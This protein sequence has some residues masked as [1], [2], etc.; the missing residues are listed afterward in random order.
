MIYISSS[1]VKTNFI[2][3]A[4]IKLY[5][6]GF[7]HIELSGG[8][9]YY[10]EIEI[11]IIE[12]KEQ[13]NLNLLCHNYFPPPK[14][15]FVLNLA[16]L[17]NEIN[18]TTIKH[19]LTAIE[20]SKKIQ[21]DCFGFHAGFL[22]DFHTDEIGKRISY[23]KLYDREKALEKFFNGYKILEQNAGNIKLY[24]ENNV[25]SQSNRK[26]FKNNNPFLLTNSEDYFEFQKEINFN[27][28][29]DIAH[30]KVSSQTLG[31]DYESELNKLIVYSDYWHLSDNDGRHDTNCPFD[32]K[33]NIFKYINRSSQRILTLE[34][35][36]DIKKI[37][38]IYRL[39]KTKLDK[40]TL[41]LF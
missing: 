1:C 8:T 39:L 18:D 29:L 25:F 27:L 5:N 24:I 37:Q 28:L 22:I 3:E 20:L 34:I 14:K 32:K 31:N 12:L 30:L 10:E 2:K 17:D 21:A 16:S 38:D 33:S 4:I 40:P 13:Y 26:S 23:T 15:H 9:D 41:S 36:D 35:Y 19:Y 11:D 7:Q 6:A